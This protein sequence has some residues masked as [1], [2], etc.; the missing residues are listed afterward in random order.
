MAASTPSNDLLEFFLEVEVRI[1][2]VGCVLVEFHEEVDVTAGRVERPNDC[3]TE[4]GQPA[5][6][7]L[8]THGS[9]RV[10][11]EVELG[12]HRS[13]PSALSFAQPRRAPTEWPILTQDEWATALG[14][15]QPNVSELEKAENPKLSTLPDDSL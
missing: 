15:R 13:P 11:V 8:T 4:H 7:K 3:R 10:L 5:H 9:D 12:A 2:E 14:I 1:E 6:G